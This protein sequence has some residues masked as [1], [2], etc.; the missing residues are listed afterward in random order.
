MRK[1]ERVFC[2]VLTMGDSWAKG[3]ISVG[4]SIPSAKSRSSGASLKGKQMKREEKEA[5]G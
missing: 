4:A 2:S 3:R 1:R 5:W